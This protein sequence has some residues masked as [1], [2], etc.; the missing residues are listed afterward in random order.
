MSGISEVMS[1]I[2]PVERADELQGMENPND[3]PVS[4]RDVSFLCEGWRRM[5]GSQK[6]AKK[7]RATP[8]RLH[9]V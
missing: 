3:S 7:K 9:S 1:V 6:H 5:D 2:V 4:I 8:K